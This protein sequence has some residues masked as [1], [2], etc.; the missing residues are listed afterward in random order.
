[1][2]MAAVDAGVSGAFSLSVQWS[3]SLVTP[4]WHL[5]PAAPTTEPEA[6]PR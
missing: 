2:C 4:E 6:V 5:Y 3:L 1:M